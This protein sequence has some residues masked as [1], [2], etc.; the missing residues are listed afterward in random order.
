MSDPVAPLPAPPTRW[1]LHWSK[2]G[3]LRRHPTAE[4]DVW[5]EAKEAVYLAAEV[6]PWKADVEA[7]LAALHADLAGYHDLLGEINDRTELEP[8]IQARVDA[9][10]IDCKNPVCEQNVGLRTQVAE[11][12]RQLQ[13][14]KRG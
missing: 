6:D 1:L 10:L 14:A 3:L 8:S 7:R 13:E 12:T 9:V 4:H 11:L 5:H 2:Y